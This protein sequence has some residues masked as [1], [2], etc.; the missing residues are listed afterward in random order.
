MAK[1]GY[2]FLCQRMNF[3]ALLEIRRILQEGEISVDIMYLETNTKGNNLQI[4]KES[5]NLHKNNVKSTIS[6]KPK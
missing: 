1:K 4:S 2:D 6:G 5:A 3:F